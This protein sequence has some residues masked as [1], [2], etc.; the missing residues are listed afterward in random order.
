MKNGDG[1]M[2]TDEITTATAKPMMRIVTPAVFI[3]LHSF[4]NASAT[5]NPNGVNFKKKRLAII[6]T[7]ALNSNAT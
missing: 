1:S 7:T 3:F 4:H 5:I 6:A 2:T